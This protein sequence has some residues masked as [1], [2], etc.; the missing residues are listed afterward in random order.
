[1][2]YPLSYGSLAVNDQ[3]VGSN[4]LLTR[5]LWK[6]RPPPDLRTAGMPRHWSSGLRPKPC[7]S[8]P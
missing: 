4:T 5:T 8:D 6:H 7:M 3:L 2:L 1:M